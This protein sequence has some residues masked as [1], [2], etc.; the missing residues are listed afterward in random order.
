MKN[1]RLEETE[2]RK[3]IQFFGYGPKCHVK[4]LFLGYEEHVRGG[5]KRQGQNLRAR[6]KF[7]PVM[8]MKEAHDKFH[9]EDNPYH[10]DANRN[11]VKVW[12]FA[13]RFALKFER[14]SQWS[15]GEVWSHYWRNSL[16]RAKG[17]TFLMECGP[18]PKRANKEKIDLPHPWDEEKIWKYRKAV[19]AK[20]LKVL[21]PR[22]VIAYGEKT[23]QK[24]GDLFGLKESDWEDKHKKRFSVAS[25][26]RTQIAHV[27]FFGQRLAKRDI[28]L[29]VDELMERTKSHRV[30]H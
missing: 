11:R 4:I 29:V 12:N 8:D 25:K 2:I 30:S 23:K 22:F 17:N 27:G 13:A 6:M 15:N 1:G 19:L 28:P 14:H 16:G 5:R 24:V 20:Y 9:K 21:A 10:D 3:L 18:I 7:T 26:G